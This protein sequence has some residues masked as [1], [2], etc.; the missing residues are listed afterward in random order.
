MADK[1]VGLGAGILADPMRLRMVVC[2]VA[3]LILLA[4]II[5]PEL[6]SAGCGTSACHCGGSC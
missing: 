5:S 6:V 2:A 1:V 3:V 4:G